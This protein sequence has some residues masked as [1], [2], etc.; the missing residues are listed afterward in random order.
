MPAVAVHHTGTSDAS[1]DAGAQTKNIPS[2]A[3]AGVLG[4]V[5]AWKP[6]GDEADSK[7]NWKFPHHFVGGDGKPGDASTVACSAVVAALNGGRGGTTIPAGDKRGVYNHVIAHLKDAGVKEADLPEL[8]AAPRS[9]HRELRTATPL[10]QLREHRGGMRGQHER[11]AQAVP[12]AQFEVRAKPDGTGGTS[13]EFHGYAATFEQPFA[14]WDAW[15]DPYDEIL[16]AGSCNRTLANGCDTQFLIGHNEASIALARTRSGTMKLAADST[17]LDVY[18]PA[19]DG[20]SPIVQSLASAMERGDMDEMSIG[21]VCTQQAWSQDWMTRRVNE[22]SLNRGDVSVVCW[23]ANPNAAG[24]SM[25]GVPVSEAARRP[26]AGQ[27]R[28]TPTAPYSAGAGE[29]L[30]CPQCHS[31]N[32]PASSYCDQ[33]GTAVKAAATSPQAGEEQTQRCP[34]GSWNAPDAKFCRDC[35]TNIASDSDADNGGSGNGPTTAPSLWDW[36]RPERRGDQGVA[37]DFSTKPP[38]NVAGHGDASLVC[39]NAD[40]QAPNAKD[41]GYCDQCGSC[42]YDEGGL[43]EAG[44]SDDVVDDTSGLIEEEDMTL[45]RQQRVRIL[46]LRGRG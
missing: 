8:K 27:E 23:A 40:C 4:D 17:G 2:D 35:G 42:L 14:M 32:E 44:S 20:R 1:W 16:S 26:A 24:A 13:F 5:Y 18:V 30:E 37:P 45:A 21:V 25:V 12:R 34:C 19:L 41:A 11:R 7:S 36:S 9:P 46:E 22:I 39:P 28:R 38:Q 3:T 15:G 43:I 31:M 6:T 29:S 33:C 10:Q